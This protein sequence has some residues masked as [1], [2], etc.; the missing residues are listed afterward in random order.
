MRIAFHVPRA[1]YLDPGTSGDK[2]N[3]R[4]LVEGLTDA[5]HEVRLVSRLNVRDLWRGRIPAWRIATEAFRVRNEMRAFS[6]HAWLVYGPSTTDPDLL[7]W[8][9]HRGRYVLIQARG[10]RGR[11]LSAA[12]R[13]AAEPIDSD[14]FVI[15]RRR[16]RS[17]PSKVSNERSNAME[18]SMLKRD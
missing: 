7:G 2:T 1:S 17:S 18:I 15:W 11:R 13:A 12:W 4:N 8:W 3:V 10:G 14:K 5:G 16:A 9:Q 6:P